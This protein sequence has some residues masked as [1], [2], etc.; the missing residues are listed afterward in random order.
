MY[1]SFCIE[2]KCPN[3]VYFLDLENIDSQE[4]ES[5]D[6][7]GIIHESHPRLKH[8]LMPDSWIGWPYVKIILYLDFMN[9]KMLI[10]K[11]IIHTS[12]R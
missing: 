5:Y 9:C 11:S 12:S 8:I 6:M 7:L 4:R 10:N 3:F 2:A 1:K